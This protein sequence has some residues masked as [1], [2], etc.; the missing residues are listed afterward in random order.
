MVWPIITKR[1]KKR[2]K[3]GTGGKGGKGGKGKKGGK[4][5]IKKRR[6]Y[7]KQSTFHENLAIDVKVMSAIS[8]NI[9]KL[10]GEK[11]EDREIRRE[12]SE[13]RTGGYNIIEQK[14]QN[15][16][17]RER[18]RERRRKRYKQGER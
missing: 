8:S 15:T 11:K 12:K 16:P 9:T 13:R 2:R 4:G 7:I 3:G 18:E 6:G 14:R 10:K 1:V 17:K 5:R